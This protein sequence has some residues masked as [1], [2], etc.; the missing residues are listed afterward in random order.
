M[1]FRALVLPFIVAALVVQSGPALA[2]DPTAVE[3]AMGSYRGFFLSS[4]T[5][6]TGPFS[7]D[8]TETHN[9]QLDGTLM[10]TGMDFPFHV[11]VAASHVF[12]AVGN[13][14]SFVA[15]GMVDVMPDGS[16]I[17]MADYRL[18]ADRGKLLFLHPVPTANPAKLSDMYQGSF[19]RDDGQTGQLIIVVRQEGSSFQG[20]AT[21]LIDTGQ[22]DL[23]PITLPYLATVGAAG[24]KGAPIHVISLTPFAS[25]TADAMLTLNGNI[26]GTVRVMFG[27][28]SVHVARFDLVPPS[29]ITTH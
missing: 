24:E 7:F 29:P 6:E 4:L 22:P 11:T 3:F 18:G 14:G 10:V 26:M 5:G 21:F 9:R 20:M 13:G 1:R 8:L 27:D 2:G 12:N 16:S 17:S 15:H 28:G 19:L 25:L 23:L